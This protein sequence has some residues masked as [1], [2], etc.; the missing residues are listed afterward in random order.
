MDQLLQVVLVKAKILEILIK[1]L[2]VLAKNES[3]NFVRVSS[4]FDRT[5][6][7]EKIFSDLKFINAPM[8]SSAYEAT[9]KLDL[10]PS[11]DQLLK[12]MRKTTRYLIK[13][14]SENKDIVIEKTD[15]QKNIEIY[16]KLNKEVSKSQKFVGF[17]NKFIKNEFEA[18]SK[19]P[20]DLTGYPEVIFLF[21]KYKNELL[22]GQ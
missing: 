13:K 3:A 1:W 21:G 14:A 4:F 7:N 18:F 12:N 15:D 6:E 10:I 20:G 2:K 19:Q 16:Q 11:E 5:P 17:S 9:W 22:R 8:H